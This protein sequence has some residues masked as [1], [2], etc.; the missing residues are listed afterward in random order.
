MFSWLPYEADLNEP[1][2][3]YRGCAEKVQCGSMRPAMHW[4]WRRKLSPNAVREIMISK[5]TQTYHQFTHLLGQLLL[6]KL[7][8]VLYSH[9]PHILLAK[10]LWI[11]HAAIGWSRMWIMGE[12]MESG[13][14]WALRAAGSHATLLVQMDSSGEW[15]RG[16][17]ITG[18]GIYK[19]IGLWC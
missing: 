11:A 7:P 5:I 4:D 9:K 16:A 12:T 10:S 18:G 15:E 19:I 6:F 13:M 3:N 1:W 17:L 14:A 2:Q 8:T